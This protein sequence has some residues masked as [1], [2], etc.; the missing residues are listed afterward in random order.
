[1]ANKPTTVRHP[2]TAV[3]PDG[4]I[5]IPRATADAKH[6]IE[7]YSTGKEVMISQ[8]QVPLG[9]GTFLTLFHHKPA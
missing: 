3:N 4:T 8:D 9:D 2:K 6:A 1:M 5:N 7:Q